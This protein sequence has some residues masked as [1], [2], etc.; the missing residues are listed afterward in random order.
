MDEH[1]NLFASNHLRCTRQRALIYHA[2]KASKTHPTAEELFHHI[3]EASPDLSL[4]TVYNTLDALVRCGL[5]RRIPSPSPS[6]PCRFD[7][8]THD[9]A[10]V[11]FDDGRVTDVPDDLS[12]RLLASL[13][14]DVLASV[15]DALGVRIMNIAVQIHAKPSVLADGKSESAHTG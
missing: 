10:H 2:L 7:A 11:L 5:C 9:H 8:E 14:D 4:A 12:D 13:P 15:E 6:G 1:R 3:R